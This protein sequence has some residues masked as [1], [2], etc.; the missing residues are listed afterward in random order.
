MSHSAWSR[1]GLSECLPALALAALSAVASAAPAAVPPAGAAR[2]DSLRLTGRYAEARAAYSSVEKSDPAVAVVGIARCLAAVGETDRAIATLSASAA[3]HPSDA[4][5]E[6]EL[7][8]LEFERGNHEAARTHVD[9]ALALDPEQCAARFLAAELDRVAGKLDDANDAYLWLVRYYNRG[10]DAIADPERLLW[11]GRAAAQYARWNRNAG[12]FSF[13]VNTLYPRARRLDRRFWPAHLE[14]ARLFLEKY[15]PEDARAELD[16][17]LAINPNAAELHAVRAMIAVERGAFD[18]ARAGIDR[19]LAINP[20]CKPAF[21]I[22][23]DLEM[24]AFGPAGAVAILERARKLDPSDEETLGRLAAAYGAVDGLRDTVPGARMRGVIAE[25]VRHNEHCGEFFAALASALDRLLKYPH[26]ARYYE[27]ARRRM[28]QLVAVSGQLGM[29][30][31]RLGEEKRA[32]ELLQESFRA[33]PFNSRVKN[34]LEV[35]DLLEGYGTIETEHFVV[36]HDRGRDSLLAKYAA[37]VLEEEIYPEITGRLGFR[38]PGKSLIEIFSSAN[39][40]SAHGW[41]SARM[42]GLPFIGTVAGCAGKIVGMASPSDLPG[43]FDWARVLRHEFVHVVNLQQTDFNIPHWYTEGLA[44][45]NEDAPRLPEWD[46]ILAR[47]AAAGRLFTLDNVNLGFLRPSTSDDWPLAY[48]QSLLY[49]EYLADTYGKD[50]N[51]RLIAAYADNLDTPRA[52]ERC[53][54]VRVEKLESGYRAYVE[55]IAATVP[56]GERTERPSP[57]ALERAVQRDPANA[58]ALAQLADANLEAGGRARA[59]EL[60]TQALAAKPGQPLAAYVMARLRAAAGEKEEAWKLLKDAVR[61]EAPEPKSLG[62][63]ADLAR[64]RGDLAEAERLCQIGAERFPHAS[65]WPRGLA[66][67]YEAA[68]DTAQLTEALVRLCDMEESDAT[69]REMLARLAMARGDAAAAG[70][71]AVR[72]LHI[73]VMNAEAHG[74]V[75]ETSAA[76]GRFERAVEEYETAIRLGGKRQ[77]WLLGLARACA[78][79]N[80]SERAREA[81]RD[82]LETDPEYP[83]ARELLK[84]LR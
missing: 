27:E 24:S 84:T 26:A 58:E 69:A 47:R 80:R 51:A 45:L 40:T 39:G 62:L 4:A 36:R 23:A 19:A 9:A 20:S 37:R 14:A 22:A 64:E 81:L 79:T 76:G 74:I 71:W 78:K 25:A 44:V 48:C 15:N 63:L 31:M 61:P 68:R 33:D 65:A 18:S 49:T 72:T 66:A 55:K 38:P 17:A 11:I 59:R 5:L 50:A 82:L 60:A 56:P 83:G 32:A 29:V 30:W 54:G 10:R 52:L 75:A 13:L 6:A 42:A 12:Q 21:H 34:T 70:S 43:E 41:F 2:A 53:F 28:P 1:R 46:V 67:A 16:S 35:L 73:D 77:A 8:G 3:K 57:A 7:A